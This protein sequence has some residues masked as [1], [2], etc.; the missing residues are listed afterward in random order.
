MPLLVSVLADL[1]QGAYCYRVRQCYH[2][3]SPTYEYLQCYDLGPE[4]RVVY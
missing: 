1:P 3:Q 4:H 2:V